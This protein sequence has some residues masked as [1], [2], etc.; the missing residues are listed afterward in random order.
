MNGK[1]IEVLLVEDEAA[2]AEAIRRVLESSG[3]VKVHI[4]GSLKEFRDY[5]AA[6]TP[7]IAL[8]D[9]V[10]PDGNGIDLLSSIPSNIFPIL[11]LTSRGNEMVAVKALK[12]GAKDYVVKSPEIFAD[13]PRILTRNLNQWSLIRENNKAQE[14]L[15]VSEANFRNSMENS[16]LGIRIVSEDGE[17][18]YTNRAFLNIYGYQSI[19][20]FNTTL[21]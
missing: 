7:D 19:E 18:L 13:M 21:V 15:Q 5:V 10:L 8:L 11:I 3:D 2:H 9:M 14:A 12:A 16:P 4:V 20:E 6:N 17:T 1:Q